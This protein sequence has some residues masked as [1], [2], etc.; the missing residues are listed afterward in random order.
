M[1]RIAGLS[2][3]VW[4]L[5]AFIVSPQLVAQDQIVHDAEYYI[6]EAQ[7]GDRWAAEDEALDARLAELREE[8]GTPPN[9]I[10]FMF[11]D[12]PVMSFGDPI[13]QKIRGYDTP[14]MNTLAEEG[15][16][17]ARMYTEPGCTPTRS[18]VT[19]GQHPVRNGI[20]EIGFPIEYRGMADEN[21]TLAEVMSEAGYAT[22]F[23]GKAHLGDVEEG[24]L[25]NQGYDE[26]LWTIYNQV[27]SLWIPQAEAGNAVLGLFPDML[28]EN[29]Y[30]LDHSFVQGGYVGYLE[31]R[32][33]EQAKEWCGTTKECYDEFDLE[34]KRRALDF[35][36]RNAEAGRPFFLSWWPQ[37]VSFIPQPQKSSLQRGIAG[38]AYE[39][40]LDPAVGELMQTLRDLGI[41]EN[42]LVV[43][44]ADN[45]PMTHDPPPGLGMGEGIFRG[46]KGDFLEGG[47]RVSAAAWWPG[48]ID[49]DQV[50]GD[51][52]HVTDLYT[53]FARLAGAT[54][55]IPTDRVIDGVDQTS[56]LL[57]GDGNGRR[58]YVFI[59][60]GHSLAATVKDH[61]KRHWFADPLQAASGI[62]AA[63]F[64]LYNDPR[65]EV[66]LLI[67]L[68]HFKEPFNRMRARHEAWM[69]AYPNF[70]P[71]YGPAY[72]GISNARP[73]TRALSEPPAAMQNLP[74]PA[75]EYIER[76]DDLPF[77]PNGEP[78]AN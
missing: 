38:D 49:G 78:D 32:K 15:M 64:D 13:Y 28:P 37:W 65:E 20:Y 26:A 7:N 40:I 34:A 8:H 11:D 71:V 51:I 58:D 12:Q 60:A 27:F 54:E 36:R 44:M 29:P 1:E 23:Y 14:H 3:A 63:Y 73:E 61:Y 76:L 41:A 5:A 57:N 45:G 24:Y 48:M 2:A 62:G 18:A 59:Y 70:E 30:R 33:G 77:D 6:L 75:L 43:V 53:T 47:V 52:I 31:A 67:N 35:I 17:F 39:S 56:L 69:E 74:F 4:L 10:H 50:P 25:H 22:A 72:T 42:T 9:I 16:L 68:L 21:V 19:T 66:P 46:G 55:Y